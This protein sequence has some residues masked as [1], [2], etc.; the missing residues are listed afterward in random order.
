MTP[1][2][3]VTGLSAESLRLLRSGLDLLVPVDEEESFRIAFLADKLAN[4][5]PRN[6]TGHSG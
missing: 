6:S 2:A 4:V 3:T 1:T 5:R